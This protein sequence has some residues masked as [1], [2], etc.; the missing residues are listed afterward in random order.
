LFHELIK[1]RLVI[2]DPAKPYITLRSVLNNIPDTKYFTAGQYAVAV[3]DITNLYLNDTTYTTNYIL[4]NDEVSYTTAYS[5]YENDSKFAEEWKFLHEP[6]WFDNSMGLASFH[7]QT[8]A[9]PVIKYTKKGLY[10]I[11]LRA[12]DNPKNDLRFR[13]DTNEAYN[14]YKWSTGNQNV[15]LYVHEKPIA[16]ARA[17]ITK[18]SNDT[19]TVK[20][21]D[22]GSYDPD[23]SNSRADKGIAGREWRWKEAASTVWTAGQMNKTDC[24][25]DERYVIQLRV[26]DIEGVWSDYYTIT[27]TRTILLLPFSVWT[28]R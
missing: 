27:I 6:Y 3:Q 1:T 9:S 24:T 22:A 8:L 18:N 2:N 11:N 14:Y 4:V 28:K 16:L 17:A 13:N 23:H 19:Y 10:T 5:D 26:K 7:G 15:L 21:M 12:R 20:A 25:A